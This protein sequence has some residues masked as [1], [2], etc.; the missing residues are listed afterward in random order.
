MMT[1]AAGAE[2]F[3]STDNMPTVKPTLTQ[4]RELDKRLINAWVGHPQFTIVKNKKK[5]VFAQ[6][7][8]YCMRS[9]LH[10]IGEPQTVSYV[11]KYLLVA[12]RSNYEFEL[13]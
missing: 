2:E 9:V 12:D 8:D 6:K 5:N 7:V 1:A 13:P 3:Y 10:T 11:R 4:A